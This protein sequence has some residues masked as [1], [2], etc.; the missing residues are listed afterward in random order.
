MVELA[1]NPNP[2]SWMSRAK[3]TCPKEDQWDAV[4]L[5]TSPVTVTADVAVKKASQKGVK[6]AWL[7][8][9]GSINKAVP[10]AMI[11]AKP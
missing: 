11:M 3:T 8:A 7:L 6:D 4:S 2:P 5:T 1:M 9:K 10:M